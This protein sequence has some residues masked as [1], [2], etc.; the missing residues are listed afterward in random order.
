MLAPMEGITNH[1]V[2]TAISA[3]GGLGVVCTEFVR[4]SVAELKPKEIRSVMRPTEGVPL[5]VQ[6]MGNKPDLM[7]DTARKF[8][9]AGADIV[10]INLGCPTARA[11][12]GNVGSA[13]L[14]DPDLLY[15]VLSAMRKNISGWQ[16]AKIRAGFDDADH[17]LLIAEAV[18]AAGV[19]FIVVHPRK[20]SDFYEGVA[21]WRIIGMI[22]ERLKIPVVGNGDIWY[23]SDA[24]R[25]YDECGCDAV[26]IGRG[27]LRNPWIFKQ[28]QD[29]SN[30]QP[31]S[32]EVFN[33]IDNF[34]NTHLDEFEGHEMG[35]VK[36]AKENWR[37]LCQLFEDGNTKGREILRQQTYS[38]FRSA[39]IKYL[40]TKNSED[41]DFFGHLKLKSSGSGLEQR[42]N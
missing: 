38:D 25:M 41:F 16:S 33:Y 21:D 42:N 3:L 23:P 37:Y 24:E 26:M 7:A 8:S 35:V 5:S 2:R 17:T 34:M 19:D 39:L 40:E 20:R 9:E 29:K 18:E 12:K 14:K 11:V 30:W 31:S 15:E 22:K 32:Q 1:P 13:M 6:I 4:V 10:D 28:L 36:R 27:A